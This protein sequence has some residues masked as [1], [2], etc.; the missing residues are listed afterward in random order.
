MTRRLSI[1]WPDARPFAGRQEPFRILAASDEPD[2][3]LDDTRNRDSLGRLDLIVGCG[4]LAPDRID[5]L[6]EAFSA[7]IVFV[8]G[9]HD[10]GGPWPTPP[11]VPEPSSGPDLRS[12]APVPLLALPWPGRESGQARRDDRSGWAQ[13][14]TLAGRWLIRVPD[15]PAIVIS[16]APPL[17]ANDNPADPYHRGFAAY[18]L[19]LDRLRPPLWLHGH[20]AL[21]AAS[22][23]HC[24]YRSTTLVNVTGSVLVEIDPPAAE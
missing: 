2:P 21:A 13:V 4:D 3:F 10:R 8:R 1:T 18:R 9:N 20:A 12:F 7:P 19:L 5:F 16:H 6:G 15:A 22:S 17:R 11:A 14:L 24:R 23:W